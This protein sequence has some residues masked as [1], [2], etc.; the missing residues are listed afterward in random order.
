MY[1]SK[2]SKGTLRTQTAFLLLYLLKNTNVK[3]MKKPW[4]E[5]NLWLSLG[6]KK[7]NEMIIVLRLIK[8]RVFF[9][10]NQ[11][12]LNMFKLKTK[13]HLCVYMCIFKELVKIFLKF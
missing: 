6:E 5:N 3:A 12:I 10:S 9:I 13:I 7:E 8:L 2:G 4:N 1:Q 11:Y